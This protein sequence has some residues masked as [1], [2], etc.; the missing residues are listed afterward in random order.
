VSPAER[1]ALVAPHGA[2]LRP[3]VPSSGGAVHVRAGSGGSP[4]LSAPVQEPEQDIGTAA[5]GGLATWFCDRPS[6]CTNGYGPAD[7][8]AAVDPELGIKRGERITVYF[9]G[10]SVTVRVVDVC[11]C[12]GRRIVDLSRLAFSRLADPSKGVIPV[13]IEFGGDELPQTDTAP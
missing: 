13:S 6:T 12:K 11:S 7:L 9:E 3:P 2:G 1:D 4:T 10:R 5:I 8:I